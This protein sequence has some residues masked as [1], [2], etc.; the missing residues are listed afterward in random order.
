M[1]VAD[2]YV[3]KDKDNVVPGSFPETPSHVMTMTWSQEDYRA[4]V[5]LEDAEP[6]RKERKEAKAQRE[7]DAEAFAEAFIRKALMASP[8]SKTE[9]LDLARGHRTY[10]GLAAKV[11][12]CL[13]FLHEQGRVRLEPNPERPQDKEFHWRG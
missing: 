8:K 9:L 3:T 4:E 2:L 6:L 1:R 5:K 10:K 13:N 12:R 11:K 7:N